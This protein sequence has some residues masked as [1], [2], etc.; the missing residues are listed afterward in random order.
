MK[1]VKKAIALVAV[2]F[3]VSMSSFAQSGLSV[4]VGGNFPMGS[5]A[6]GGSL[7][8][9]ALSN[10]SSTLGGAATGLNAGLKY[11]FGIL[12]DLSVFASADLFYNGLKS[13]LKEDLQKIDDDA[14]FPSYL[15][16]PVM[17][18]ANYQLLDIAGAALWVEAGLGVN[19][20]NIS[21]LESETEILGSE[22]E[23]GTSYKMATTFAWEAGI[24]VSVAE[25]V[26]LGLHYYA[27]GS[28]TVN[29]D[30]FVKD[31]GAIGDWADQFKDEFQSGKLNPSMI[32]IRL[33]Y[34]F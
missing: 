9:I 8:D 12:G 21:S 19:F 29:G 15:N 3:G 25:K 4:R 14:E 22:F 16:I 24:G 23:T 27:F 34:H 17:V 2:I 5:F 31:G 1:N 6:E 26:S 33:G 30:P 28:S 32:V 20:R 10:A 13:D 11:Q 18:G 7:S